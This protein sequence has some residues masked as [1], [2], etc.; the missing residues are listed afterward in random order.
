MRMF[1]LLS[2]FQKPL[3]EVN[4][5]LT[6]HSVWVQQHYKSGRFLVSGRREILAMDPLQQMGLVEYEIVAFEAPLFPN[7]VTRLMPLL[8]TVSC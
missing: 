4:R 2:R 8:P 3:E 7:G 5:F 6:T 1:V